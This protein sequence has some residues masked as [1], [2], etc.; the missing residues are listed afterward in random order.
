MSKDPQPV[1]ATIPTLVELDT[2]G[3]STGTV[4]HFCSATCRTL[5]VEA[6]ETR[7]ATRTTYDGEAELLPGEICAYCG[8]AFPQPTRLAVQAIGACPPIDASEA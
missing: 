1:A 4:Y 7:E 5:F 3:E 2:D 6:G 8:D